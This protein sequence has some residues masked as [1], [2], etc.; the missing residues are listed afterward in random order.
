MEENKNEVKEASESS[1]PIP[2]E[3]QPTIIPTEPEPSSTLLVTP[4]QLSNEPAPTPEAPSTTETSRSELTHEPPVRSDY[5]LGIGIAVVLLFVGLILVFL[6]S[7]SIDPSG[8]MT[9]GIFLVVMPLIGIL[10]V[11]YLIG[12]VARG[13]KQKAETTED[14]GATSEGKRPV[15]VGRLFKVLALT[16]SIIVVIYVGTMVYQWNVWKSDYQKENAAL[17]A[18]IQKENDQ[19]I[20]DHS[21]DVISKDQ[22]I[23]LLENCQVQTLYYSYQTSTKSGRWGELS[24]T[25]VALDRTYTGNETADMSIADRHIPELVP[26]AKE[27]QK[28][29][30]DLDIVS[31]GNDDEQ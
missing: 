28:T 26:I 12:A 4:I 14:E 15:S 20:K 13:V 7:K 17:A 10:A 16:I 29:C 6:N 22:A 23:L 18:Q 31:Y 8:L 21:N 30:E 5:L 1:G 9:F 11:A 3:P 27:A 19:Y 24:A 25:G 2:A